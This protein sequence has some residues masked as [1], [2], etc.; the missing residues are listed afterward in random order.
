MSDTRDFFTAPS[1]EAFVDLQKQVQRN[2]DRLTALE[3]ESKKHG[4]LIYN[5]RTDLQERVTA[6]EN[7]EPS[8]TTSAGTTEGEATLLARDQPTGLVERVAKAFL[9][10][11]HGG[12]DF[13]PSERGLEAA[14]AAIEAT[15][16]WLEEWWENLPD[17]EVPDASS[18]EALRAQQEGG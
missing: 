5:T 3:K 16:K 12:L 4:N 14:R 7:P 11:E 1:G 2:S 9:L 6:L 15:A 18:I 8:H 13:T 10:K 17:H